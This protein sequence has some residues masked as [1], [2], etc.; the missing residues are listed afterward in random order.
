MRTI[1]VSVEAADARDLDTREGIER[2]RE[3]CNRNADSIRQ[4]LRCNQALAEEGPCEVTQES[5]PGTVADGNSD[6]ART[7]IRPGLARDARVHIRGREKSG[8]VIG[9]RGNWLVILGHADSD[10]IL[11]ITSRLLVS[12]CGPHAAAQRRHRAASKAGQMK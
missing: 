8:A 3:I 6:T 9:K 11:A 4:A 1:I 10:R 5:L 2:V 7:G 12:S